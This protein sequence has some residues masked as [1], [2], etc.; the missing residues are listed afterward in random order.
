MSG[1]SDEHPV[2]KPPGPGTEVDR[3]P[4]TGCRPVASR[5]M[6]R[7]AAA[8]GIGLFA[9]PLLVLALLFMHGLS[10]RPD[11]AGSSHGALSHEHGAAPG[12]HDD[13]PDCLHH[14]VTT[15]VAVL[16][17]LAIWRLTRRLVGRSPADRELTP[18]DGAAV[19]GTL[20]PLGRPPDPPWIRLG[21]MRC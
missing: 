18:D 10:A 7:G 3:P 21:V 2:E 20:R 16:S 12:H 4:T 17:A 13:C 1:H 5:G 6:R 14:L 9:L 15:C 19:W 8:R 11:A